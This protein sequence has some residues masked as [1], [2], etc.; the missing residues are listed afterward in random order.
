MK[1]IASLLA[2][3]TLLATLANADFARV[4]MGGGV[5]DNKSSGILSHTEN[6]L[7][8]SYTSNEKSNS[9]AYAWLMVKHPIPVI[10]NL[11]LEYTTLQDE[12]YAS[13]KFEDFE[14]NLGEFVTGE[15]KM[16]QYDAILYYNILDNT[17]WITLDVGVDVKFINLDFTVNGNIRVDGVPNTS[18]TVNETL[19]L[20]MGYVRA[21][22]QIPGTNI[23]LEADGK[24]ITYDGSSVSDFRAKVDY[25][26][27]FVPVVQP[28]IELGY[29][30]QKFD[31]QYDNERTKFALDFSGIY[32]GVMLRF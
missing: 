24:Y 27:D 16:T 2:T 31:L 18:Y 11:R 25:T 21:R 3:T 4:E 22:V 12:G 19:P 23:G 14:I 17:A 7:T 1:K 28:A 13:G 29:R 15:I 26:F 20:P 10:P 8:G 30:A 5:W 9:S 32:A 6:D